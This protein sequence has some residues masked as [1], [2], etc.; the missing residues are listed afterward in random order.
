MVTLH[1][2]LR[3]YLFYKSIL[4]KVL[5]LISMLYRMDV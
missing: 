5:E 2:V 1:V 4:N 3:R